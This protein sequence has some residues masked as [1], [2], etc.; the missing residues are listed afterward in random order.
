MNEIE[1]FDEL[2]KNSLLEA[3]NEK[4]EKL[5][6]STR[7]AS[8]L[9]LRIRQANAI[10]DKDQK[11]IASCSLLS[12]VNSLAAINLQQAKRFLPLVRGMI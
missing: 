9:F 12:A 3:N 5:G 2:Q 8:V 7:V 1:V 10:K 4:A 11:L 6:Y